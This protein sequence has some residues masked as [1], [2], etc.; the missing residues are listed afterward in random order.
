MTLLK[1]TSNPTDLL[2]YND[3]A[4]SYPLIFRLIIHN[5]TISISN[6]AFLIRDVKI[7]VEIDVSNQI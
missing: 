2:K 5:H 4:T 7:D 6:S 1:S 3:I